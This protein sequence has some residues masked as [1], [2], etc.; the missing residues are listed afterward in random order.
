MIEKIVIPAGR[1]GRMAKINSV[2]R[3]VEQSNRNP[4]PVSVRT[5]A[6]NGFLY[7]AFGVFYGPWGKGTYPTVYAYRLLPPAAFSGETTIVYHDEVAIEAGLRE[8]G[9]HRGLIVHV[10]GKP[11]V[12]AEPVHF[13]CGLPE[14]EA[15]VSLDAAVKHEQEWG[16]WG[17]RAMS[18][19]NQEPEWFSLEGHLVVRYE[20]PQ[21]HV[22]VLLWQQEGRVRDFWL[23]RDVELSPL[24][25][26]QP[27]V[28]PAY[29]SHNE[30]LGLFG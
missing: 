5:E 3:A 10:S 1:W 6:F 17:W 11:M 12:C 29:P 26:L 25:E 9:D 16:Q 7:T 18:F 15:R 23:S 28:T 14:P 30:Q 2:D 20:G 19:P 22:Q 27:V 4:K 8:R 13:L 24:E 21:T